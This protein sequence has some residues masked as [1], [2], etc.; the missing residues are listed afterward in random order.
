M[1]AF[2]GYCSNCKDYKDAINVEILSLESIKRSAM[3]GDC[4]D[5]GTKMLIIGDPIK[6]EAGYAR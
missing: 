1:I 5:C 2:E 4:P 6:V 3:K